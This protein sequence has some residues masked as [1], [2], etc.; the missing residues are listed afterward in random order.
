MN[1][2]L[3]FALLALAPAAQAECIFDPSGLRAPICGGVD[4]AAQMPGFPPP[5]EPRKYGTRT[6]LYFLGGGEV[7]IHQSLAFDEDDEFFMH[8]FGLGEAPQGYLLP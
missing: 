4:P 8:D 5:I 1:W 2:K 6:D 3:L 7:Q